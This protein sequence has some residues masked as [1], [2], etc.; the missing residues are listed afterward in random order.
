MNDLNSVPKV[1]AQKF[2]GG[3]L[4]GF[5]AS[6]VSGDNLGGFNKAGLFGGVYTNIKLK[7]NSAL[8]FEIDYIEK[9]S[10]KNPNNKSSYSYKLNLTYIELPLLYKYI[11]S[12]VLTFET[13]TSLEVLIK[14][15]FEEVNYG[16]ASNKYSFNKQNMNF[17]LGI[18]YFFNENVKINFR[19]SSTLTVTPIRPHASGARIWYNWGQ[20][21]SVLVLFLS[22]Q[23]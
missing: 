14:E 23:I 10:R 20:Y 2:K 12:D 5:T 17:I 11:Y 22:Y 8:Q 6:Q 19:Y 1:N 21:N 13:G 18:N 7:E 3:L 9:G 16:P 15:P 4:G